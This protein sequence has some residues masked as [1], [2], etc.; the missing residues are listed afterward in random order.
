MPETGPQNLE[1][2]P[3]QIKTPPAY[4]CGVFYMNLSQNLR[5]GAHDLV[6]TTS[7]SRGTVGDLLDIGKGFL[8]LGERFALV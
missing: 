6:M 5:D 3:G 7:T 1:G 2:V 4:A 8:Y